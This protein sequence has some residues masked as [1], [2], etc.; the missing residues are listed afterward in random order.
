MTVVKII[1]SEAVNKMSRLSKYGTDEIRKRES[2][3][4]EGFKPLI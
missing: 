1:T 3:Y 4:Q 2:F